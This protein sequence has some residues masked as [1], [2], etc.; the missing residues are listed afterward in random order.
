MVK[1]ILNSPGY[2][3]SGEGVLFNKHGKWLKPFVSKDGYERVRIY[4]KLHNKKVNR[5]IHL[6]VAEA[7]LNGGKYCNDT[8]QVNHKDGNK[9]NNNVSNLELVSGTVNV[10]HAHN[11]G[12]YNFNVKIKLYD[13]F[14][15]KYKTFRSL[16]YLAKYLNVS[17]NYIRARVIISQTF[18]I[19]GRY[20]LYMDVDNYINNISKIKNNKL[21]YT[22][23]HLTNKYNTLT[24]YVQIS[25]LYGVSYITVMKNLFK[26]P[27]EY[28]YYGGVTFSLLPIKN[29]V[30]IVDNSVAHIDR[31][32]IWKK[33]S[34]NTMNVGLKRVGMESLKSKR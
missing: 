3:I 10:N 29:D 24:S 1:F 18:P 13:R 5:T 26:K 2:Y 12:L 23:C 27:D 30:I 31:Y 9:R 4:S 16:R 22:Y 6:L 7:F 20:R 21:L 32:T 17:I 33:L 34:M 28:F 14:T 25:I 15:N 19:L 11:L 8:R